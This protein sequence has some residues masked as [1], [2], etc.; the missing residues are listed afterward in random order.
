MLFKTTITVLS[1]PVLFLSVVAAPFELQLGHQ[2]ELCFEFPKTTS[3]QRFNIRVANKLLQLTERKDRDYRSSPSVIEDW[4]IRG[5]SADTIAGL[6]EYWSKGYNWKVV[7][8][9]LN[10]QKHYATTVPGNGNYS[11]PIPIHFVHEKLS[12]KTPSIT[13]YS[14]LVFDP[15]RVV[16]SN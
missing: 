15:S 1:T 7:E 6:V 12:I 14:W 10:Q 3:P 16:E 5:P 4:S 9:E 13:S 8:K 11:A 2:K